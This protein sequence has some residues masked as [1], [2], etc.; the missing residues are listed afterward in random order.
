[1]GLLNTPLEVLVDL[2]LE[3]CYTNS[4][5]TTLVTHARIFA[6][7]A[8]AAVGQRRRY[9]NEPYIQHPAEVVDILQTVDPTAEMVAAAW[10]HDVLEDTKVTYPVLLAEFGTDV[11][12]L[13]SC[14]TDV[15]Q[16]ADGNRRQR[17]A[18]DREHLSRAP[19]AAQTIKVADLISN[20]KS[21]VDHDPGFARVYLKEK[22]LLLAVLTQADPRLVDLAVRMLD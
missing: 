17:K 6:T 3:L 21:I 13:V 1:M 20:S 16:P 5:N 7:A 15:S 11:A 4:M 19:A 10:L 2:D 18:R 12:E 9:T 22:R 8:H 14:L